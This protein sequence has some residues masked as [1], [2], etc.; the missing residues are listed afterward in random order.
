MESNSGSIIIKAK[1]DNEDTLNLELLCDDFPSQATYPPEVLEY[2][3][4]NYQIEWRSNLFCKDYEYTRD[5]SKCY[6]YNKDNKLIDLTPLSGTTYR[7]ILPGG[8]KVH[9]SV[10]QTIESDGHKLNAA[11]EEVPSECDGAAA[12]QVHNSEVEATYKL[13][14]LRLGEADGHV[15]LHYSSKDDKQDIKIDFYY[16]HV[17]LEGSPHFEYS[18]GAADSSENI[19]LSS[20]IGI[21]Q[22]TK[23]A[24]PRNYYQKPNCIFNAALHGKSINLK[25]EL[26]GD[27]DRFEIENNGKIFSFSMCASNPNCGEKGGNNFCM[28]TDE[29]ETNL[30][31]F[32]F[33]RYVDQTFT[34][35]YNKGDQVGFR[36]W[37]KSTS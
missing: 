33:V 30:G 1:S 36:K 12:C 5:T 11:G 24:Q 26:G 22:K 20:S 28:K 34:M 8:Y 14:D 35:V 19:S 25:T 16:D 3:N 17:G 18:S 23:Y 32:Q 13:S 21:G 37:S 4:N 29:N 10:C 9:Y 15:Q 31:K 7:I 27:A 6:T 2:Y